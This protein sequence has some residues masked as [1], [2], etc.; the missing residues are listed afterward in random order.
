MNR[1]KFFFQDQI[2]APSF[3]FF[4][5]GRKRKKIKRN[6]KRI[7][8][9]LKQKKNLALPVAT[10][11]TAEKERKTLLLFLKIAFCDSGGNIYI[12]I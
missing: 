2:L 9:E 8:S 7:F 1:E 11:A 12:Y 3:G 10:S 5:A 4:E 6:Q